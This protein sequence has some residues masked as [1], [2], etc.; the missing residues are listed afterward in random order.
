MVKQAEQTMA[1]AAA[2]ALIA[3]S[4]KVVVQVVRV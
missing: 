2:V 4:H 1:A 3:Q